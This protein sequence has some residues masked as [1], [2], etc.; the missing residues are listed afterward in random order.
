MSNNPQ[1]IQETG[2]SK[3]CNVNTTDIPNSNSKDSPTV[4]DYN[5]T[6]KLFQS[7]PQTSREI[8]HELHK[9]F[10]DVFTGIGCIDSTFPLQMKPE[11]KPYQ[12]HKT[13]SLC[14]AE[15]S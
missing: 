14:L 3:K 2:K 12:A 5:N 10:Y 6:Q 11:S 8:T 1:K 4:T 15:T 13:C 9:E 7:R